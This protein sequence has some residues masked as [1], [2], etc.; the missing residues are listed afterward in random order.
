MTD[1]PDATDQIKIDWTRVV[2]GA[3]AAV[4]SAVLL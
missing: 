3:L 4:T 1:D 2:A